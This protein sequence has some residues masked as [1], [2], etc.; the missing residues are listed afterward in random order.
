MKSTNSSSI[1]VAH[2]PLML[3]QRTVAI[4]KNVKYKPNP[5]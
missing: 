1:A 3:Q 4:L 2:C 5:V